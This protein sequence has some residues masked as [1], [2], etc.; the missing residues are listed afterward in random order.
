MGPP[1]P[2]YSSGAK[3]VEYYP[4]GVLTPAMGIFHAIFSYAGNVTLSVLADRDILPDA[5]LY[6]DC[7]VNSYE[8]LYAAIQKLPSS[9]STSDAGASGKAR[10]KTARRKRGEGTGSS[11]SA[12]AARKAGRGAAPRAPRKAA[13][14]TRKTAAKVGQG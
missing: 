8:E 4:L 6:H 11:Q 3:M 7:L 2:L 5:A 12:K 10:V 9:R 14:K 13:P 1:I